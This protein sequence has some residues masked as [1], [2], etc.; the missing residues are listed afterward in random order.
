MHAQNRREF[1]SSKVSFHVES[2]DEFHIEL[3]D[4]FDDELYDEIHDEL[5]NEIGDRLL[6]NFMNYLSLIADFA[7]PELI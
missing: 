3:Y 6:N 5:H 4:E 1:E 2:F 7:K